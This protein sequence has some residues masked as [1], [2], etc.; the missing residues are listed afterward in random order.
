[1]L[2]LFLLPCG[3]DSSNGGCSGSE[4]REEEDNGE[5]GVPSMG[6]IEKRVLEDGE[7]DELLVVTTTPPFSGFSNTLVPP[8]C[9][10]NI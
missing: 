8:A 7:I 10:R 4:F 5:L 9:L 1:M 2:Y 3:L 6:A